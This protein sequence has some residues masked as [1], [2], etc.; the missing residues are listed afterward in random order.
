MKCFKCNCEYSAHD[1]YNMNV[2]NKWKYICKYCYESIFLN[3]FYYID[4][5]INVYD[6]DY[7]L[8]YFGKLNTFSIPELHKKKLSIRELRSQYKDKLFLEDDKNMNPLIKNS[9][10]E[11]LI[12]NNCYFKFEL[13]VFRNNIPFKC[14]V[15]DSEIKTDNYLFIH[16]N[17]VYN[18]ICKNCFDKYIKKGDNK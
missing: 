15:C 3:K 4:L 14:S 10:F 7:D 11:S 1:I 6:Y 13:K 18:R 5:Y 8:V 12:K 9:N 16:K 2:N 17:N